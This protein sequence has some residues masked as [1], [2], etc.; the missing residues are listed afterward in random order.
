[1]TYKEI[2]QSIEGYYGNYK[3]IVKKVVYL[4]LE[5]TF[6]EKDLD[7]IFNMVIKNYS[8]QYR[9]T[10]D[11]AVIEKIINEYNKLNDFPGD[12]VE[13]IGEI[14]YITDDPK[15]SYLFE[16]RKQIE[17]KEKLKNI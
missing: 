4:Y 17:N 6:A 10:P 1:M 12:R 13:R 2:I 5:S 9:H 15:Y 8:G 16:D 11:V 14:I 7:K 3:L